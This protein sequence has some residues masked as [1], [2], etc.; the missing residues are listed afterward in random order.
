MKLPKAKLLNRHIKIWAVPKRNRLERVDMSMTHVVVFLD[1]LHVDSF[2]YSIYISLTL[3][4]W[5]T[6]RAHLR[7]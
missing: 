4:I 3:P 1:V 2:L 7:M 6:L 5:Y